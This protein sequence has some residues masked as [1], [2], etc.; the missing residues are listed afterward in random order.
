MNLDELKEKWASYDQ[1]LDQAIRLNEIR[2][3]LID[4]RG[5]LSRVF[6]PAAAGLALDGIAMLILGDFI[7][8]HLSEPEFWI[9]ALVLDAFVIAHIAWAVRQLLAL[10]ALDYS[11]PVVTIQRTL[12]ALRLL[13][14]QAVK[15][16]LALS[17]LLW[18]ALLVVGPEAL[19]GLNVYEALPISYLAANLGFGLAFLATVMWVARHV[20]GR[21]N[22]SPW[23]ETLM[24]HLAGRSLTNARLTLQ[25]IV[26]FER[27]PSAV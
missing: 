17:P 8:S 2:F 1:K 20:E 3:R 26:D 7:A 14:V 10:R 21:F 27:E 12:A 24:D 19:V 5:S 18:T 16:T 13:R 11:A 22:G 6:W 25:Q 15:W 9:P 4:V 23:L